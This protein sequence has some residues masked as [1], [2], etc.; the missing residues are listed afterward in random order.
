MPV[1]QYRTCIG[2]T[3]PDPAEQSQQK[4][5]FKKKSCSQFGLFIVWSM[6]FKTKKLKEFQLL[7]GPQ[8]K[9]LKLTERPPA[10][11]REHPALQNK[12]FLKVFLFG[13]VSC[14]SESRSKLRILCS[15]YSWAEDVYHLYLCGGLKTHARKPTHNKFN[16]N[17]TRMQ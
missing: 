17:H 11:W 14:L 6:F 5:G 15:L 13:G 16:Y 12:K 7:Y 2:N 4:K 8:R 3:D 1:G 9:T 10:M